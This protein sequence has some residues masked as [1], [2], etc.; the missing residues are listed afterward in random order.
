MAITLAQLSDAEKVVLL[1]SELQDAADTLRHYTTTNRYQSV[2]DE[3]RGDQQE[4]GHEA[5]E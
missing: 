2:I 1:L 3:M 4:E 5:A